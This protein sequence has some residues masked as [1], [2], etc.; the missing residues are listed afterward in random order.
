MWYTC[1]LYEGT[2]DRGKLIF[3]RKIQIKSGTEGINHCNV[4][5][6]F[7][8]KYRHHLKP[9]YLMMKDERGLGTGF[10]WAYDRYWYIKYEG[11]AIKV[12]RGGGFSLGEWDG[13]LCGIHD[14]TRFLQKKHALDNLKILRQYRTEVEQRKFKLVKVVS[15]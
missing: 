8:R 5:K 13:W 12:E 14:V 15:K 6:L 4:E 11:R 1:S 2:N 10:L 7:A 9:G 3:S